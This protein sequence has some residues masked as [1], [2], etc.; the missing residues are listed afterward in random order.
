MQRPQRRRKKV[1]F[2]VLIEWRADIVV[3][4]FESGLDMSNDV[5]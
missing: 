1:P 5:L 2:H 4:S 3:H